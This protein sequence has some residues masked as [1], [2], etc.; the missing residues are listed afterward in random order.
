MFAYQHYDPIILSSSCPQSS[1]LVTCAFRIGG[2]IDPEFLLQCQIT[3][4]IL[5]KKIDQLKSTPINYELLPSSNSTFEEEL[6]LD[7][8][9][10]DTTSFFNRLDFQHYNSWLINS[11][12][13]NMIYSF[14]DDLII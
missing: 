2:K 11:N 14:N 1:S 5:E 4:K 3:D 10:Q 7:I 12:C 8:D 13:W 6:F 9:L